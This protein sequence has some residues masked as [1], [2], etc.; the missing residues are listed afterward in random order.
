MAKITADRHH[1]QLCRRRKRG[2]CDPQLE[3]SRTTPSAAFTKEGEV[4]SG[5]SPSDRPS[6]TLTA[7]FIKRRMGSNHKD[8][9]D[10]KEYPTGHAPWCS[11]AE[12]RR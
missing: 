4:L 11:K 7:P 10:G 1:Q 9:I 8:T 2:R 5:R 6:P 3:G 12:G